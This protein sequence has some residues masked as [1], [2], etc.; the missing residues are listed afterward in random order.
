MLSESIYTDEGSPPTILLSS[1]EKHHLFY[2]SIFYFQADIGKAP[3]E[4]LTYYT[5]VAH[6]AYLLLYYYY[7]TTILCSV[8]QLP[9]RR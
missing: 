7:T 1:A 9:P 8:L 5:T 4:R 3:D 2:I 6:C